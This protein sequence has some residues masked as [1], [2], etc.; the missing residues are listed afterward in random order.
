MLSSSVI[1]F[2]H[3]GLEGLEDG[4]DKVMLQG[5][6]ICMRIVVGVIA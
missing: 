5:I 4:H 6:P 1:K 2:L 3:F